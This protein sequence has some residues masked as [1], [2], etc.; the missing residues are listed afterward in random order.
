M[1]RRVVKAEP[2]KPDLEPL[3]AP[4]VASMEVIEEQLRASNRLLE[5]RAKGR[6]GEA[7]LIDSV[8]EMHERDDAL[9]VDRAALI[10]PRRF[11]GGKLKLHPLDAA[12]APVGDEVNAMCGNHTTG[13]VSSF[14]ISQ[15]AITTS[16]ARWRAS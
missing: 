5:S 9:P 15:C 6:T 1:P 7:I 12:A 11:K 16:G 2:I 10:D 14:F 3:F 8:Y 13:N 4:L